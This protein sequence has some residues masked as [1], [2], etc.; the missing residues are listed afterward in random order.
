MCF[1]NLMALR[2]STFMSD[3]SQDASKDLKGKTICNSSLLKVVVFHKI[4]QEQIYATPI[5]ELCTFID[6]MSYSVSVCITYTTL[7]HIGMYY[8]HHVM[9]TM[10]MLLR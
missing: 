4:L 2:D 1:T 7:C 3:R 9:Q 10:L 5:R 6:V 8:Y